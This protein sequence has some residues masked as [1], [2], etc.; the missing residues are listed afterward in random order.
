MDNHARKKN[1]PRLIDQV[2]DVLRREHYSISTEKNY[3]Q[4]IKRYIH[5]NN[6]R[7]PN[8]MGAE[9]IEAYLSYL[10]RNKRVS[11]STQNQALNAI[12]FLY[13]KVL[14]IELPWM[15]N[16]VRAKRK[17]N[18]P[19]VF[20]RD[21]VRAL[22]A[23]FDGT[24]W[25]VFSMIYGCGMRIMECLRLRVKD[26]DFYY[27]EIAI[28]DGKGNKDRVTV[29]PDKLFE[30][31]K[32][33]LDKAKLLH[34]QD[35]KSGYGC[36]Y[37]PYALERK[38]PNACREWGWQYVFPSK[39]ISKDPRSDMYRRHHLDEKNIQRHMKQA[40]RRAGIIKPG[41]VHTLR[42]SFATHMLEDGYDIRTVQELLGH[43]DVKTTQI[44]THVLR[45]GGK[46][47]NSPLERL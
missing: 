5:F 17:K 7:H 41:S 35:L 47:V 30:P 40:I 8:Q 21:E 2:R 24:K 45:K 11:P 22:L 46:G 29:L 25:L 9:E 15:D 26:I 31:L 1:S 33:H 19:V 43:K 39:N 18:L 13:K 4:W 36:V 12:L 42:H 10:A 16:I 28:R 3:I 23:Q 20:T 44:Y 37:L 14:K 6:K 27:K 32:L 38:Y 34:E